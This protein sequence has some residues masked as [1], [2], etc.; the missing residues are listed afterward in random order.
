MGFHG[1]M[2]ATEDVDLLIRA[3]AEN[4][5]RLR[6]VFHAVYAGDANIDEIRAVDLYFDVMTRLGKVASFELWSSS[7]VRPQVPG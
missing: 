2:R 1:L 3:T 7:S 5:A 6:R 4:I